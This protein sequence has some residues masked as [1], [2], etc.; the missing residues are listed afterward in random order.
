[1]K[2]FDLDEESMK[3]LTKTVRVDHTDLENFD[4]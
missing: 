3:N 2:D 4:D 1:M